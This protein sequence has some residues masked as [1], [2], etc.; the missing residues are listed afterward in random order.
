M[1][2]VS[3]HLFVLL[4]VLGILFYKMLTDDQSHERYVTD[5]PFTWLFIAIGIVLIYGGV[6]WW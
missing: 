1:I 2:T 4:N 6:M 3:W 5:S